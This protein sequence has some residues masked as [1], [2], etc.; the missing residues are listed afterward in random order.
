MATQFKHIDFPAAQTSS[1]APT[2]ALVAVNQAFGSLPERT[3]DEV[4]AEP[5]QL[6]LAAWDRA[7]AEAEAAIAARDAYYA[8][9]IAPALEEGER[10]FGRIDDEEPAEAQEMKFSEWETH[11]SAKAADWKAYEQLCKDATRAAEEL[12]TLSPPNPNGL[13]LAVRILCDTTA[14]DAGDAVRAAIKRHADQVLDRATAPAPYMGGLLA[15]WRR[16]YDNVVEDQREMRA[17]RDGTLAAAHQRFETAT[18]DD[19]EAADAALLAAEKEFHLC[20]GSYDDSRIRLYLTPAPSP[21][22]MAV[23]LKLIEE[24]RDW[25]LARIGEVMKHLAN[26]ARRFGRLGAFIQGDAELLSAFSELRSDEEHW[27]A[28]GPDLEGHPWNTA[29][30]VRRAAAEDLIFTARATTIEGV[31]VKLRQVFP[32][33]AEEAWSDHAMVDPRHPDFVA[34]LREADG[35]IRQLWSAIDDLAK[36]GGVD[37]ASMGASKSPKVSPLV[38]AA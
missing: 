15:H 3:L 13:V 18:E 34:G 1:R 10:T 19:R 20:V 6:D 12:A 4:A 14:I 31:L 32:T 16:L 37:L 36:L 9:H 21:A 24:E 17:Y 38:P 11:L 33:F 22:E 23:K 27:F 35:R 2:A 26:D 7:L 29:A 30:D 25:D 28:F 8:A 5:Q